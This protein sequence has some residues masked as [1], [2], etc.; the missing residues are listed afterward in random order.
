MRL[1]TTA[2]ATKHAVGTV[3]KRVSGQVEVRAREVKGRTVAD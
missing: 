1:A 3:K 2:M